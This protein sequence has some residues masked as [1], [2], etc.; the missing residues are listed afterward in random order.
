MSMLD[1]IGNKLTTLT[2]YN[3]FITDVIISIIV[4]LSAFALVIRMMLKGKRRTVSIPKTEPKKDEE[5]GGE[6]A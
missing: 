3:E 4:Y 5:K 1:I 2:P 6:Q